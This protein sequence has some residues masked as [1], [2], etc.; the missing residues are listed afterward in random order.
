MKRIFIYMIAA[1]VLWACDT[2][3][4]W[5]DTGIS[6][7][8]HDCSIMENMRK[9]TYNNR[10]TVEMIEYA[11]LTDLFEGKDKT[12]REITFFAPPSH[13]ILRYIWNNGKEKISDFT[14]ED[15][16]K[17]ILKHVVKGKFLKKDIAYR[18]MKYVITDPKQDGGSKL[19]CLEGN[20]LHV[21]VDKT[22]YGGVPEAGPEIMYIYSITAATKVPLSSPD[23]QP[24]NG[25]VH[26]LNYN[27]VLGNI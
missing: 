5:I 15:C 6:S 16:R 8:Y 12:Y 1:F 24:L 2:K 9:D 27:Y 13:T 14:K 7:P 17:L 11:G 3:Q 26:T 25:V 18:N 21:Y 10:L 19:T 22:E 4:E 23:I 20:V